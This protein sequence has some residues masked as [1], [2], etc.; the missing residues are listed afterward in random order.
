[1]MI[2]PLSSFLFQDA[3]GKNTVSVLHLQKN[4]NVSERARPQTAWT[5]PTK[6]Q[7]GELD[8]VGVLNNTH[9]E[10]ATQGTLGRARTACVSFSCC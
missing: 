2:Y 6:Q 4:S 10:S 7:L 1:M 5:G 9:L 3:V 8:G